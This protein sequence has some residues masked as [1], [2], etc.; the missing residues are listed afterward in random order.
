M[1]AI[2][3]SLVRDATSS[4]IYVFIMDLCQ[5]IWGAWGHSTFK[6]LSDQTTGFKIYVF[7]PPLG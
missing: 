6:V 3:L 1:N 5:S 2:E 4:R 7:V